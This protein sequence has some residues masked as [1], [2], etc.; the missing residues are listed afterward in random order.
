MWSRQHSGI[1]TSIHCPIYLVL[2]GYMDQN[3]SSASQFL[4]LY[5]LSSRHNDPISSFTSTLEGSMIRENLNMINLL[6]LLESVDLNSQPNTIIWS[7]EP[8]GQYT[9][10]SF[11]VHLTDILFLHGW[12]LI[13]G[14]T[15]TRCYKTVMCNRALSLDICLM[16]YT[17][18]GTHSFLRRQLACCARV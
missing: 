13:E 3:K 5:N 17:R 10:K 14:L 12:S 7:L 4:R 11:F 6:T 2:G 8:I 1:P 9:C 16:G 18:G 15:L